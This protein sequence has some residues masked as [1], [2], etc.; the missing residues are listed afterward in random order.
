[1]NWE[2]LG[3]IGEIVAA[4][5][6]VVT[7]GYLAVQIRQ[8]TTIAVGTARHSLLIG[9][10]E[11]VQGMWENED[12]VNLVRRGL[13]DYDALSADEKLVFH[14]LICPVVG[15]YENARSLFQAGLIDRSLLDAH[16][17]ISLGCIRTPGG[18][19]WWSQVRDSW[20]VTM[21]QELDDAVST[22]STTWFDWFPA[23]GERHTRDA[24]QDP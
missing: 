4:V 19:Q 9:I 8:N 5:A 13:N 2:A 20:E 6:V 12:K 17:A 1:M 23:L 15:H 10:H 16:L 24:A 21:R 22:G 3:A 18:A 7:L 14:G 11:Q